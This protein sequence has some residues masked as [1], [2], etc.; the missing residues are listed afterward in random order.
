MRFA[1]FVLLLCLSLPSRAQGDELG[2]RYW[3]SEGKSTRSHNAQNLAPSLGNPTSVLTYEDL[4]THALELYGRKNLAQD[5]FLKGNAGLGD[6]RSGSFDDEDFSRG[7]VKF[8]DTT[9]TVKGNRLTYFTLDAGKD[10]L[11]TRKWRGGSFPGL[12]LLVGAAGCVRARIHRSTRPAGPTRQAIGRFGSRDQ[13]PDD[14]AGV[15]RRSN[16]RSIPRSE[17]PDRI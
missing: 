3:Y 5:G 7:Q 8:S 4:K 14:V 15:A 12:Q 1:F 11:R 17:N 2:A 10:I 6:T 16:Q 9:S 13:Q